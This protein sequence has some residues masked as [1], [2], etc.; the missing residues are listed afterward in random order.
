[1]HQK[2][3]DVA[4]AGERD[5]ELSTSWGPGSPGSHDPLG[6]ACCLRAASATDT[7]GCEQVLAAH[8]HREQ[9]DRPP[10][11]TCLWGDEC[12]HDGTSTET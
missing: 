9:V 6:V 1:M 12:R 7:C 5:G 3:P 2:L 8:L 10:R 4:R 11:T